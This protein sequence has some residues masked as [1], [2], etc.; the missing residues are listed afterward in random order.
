MTTIYLPIAEVAVSLPLLL[1]I[2]GGVGLLSGL[3]GVGGGFLLTP[4]LI[5]VG[6]PPAVAVG[7]EANQLVAASLSG[8]VAH[9]R[10]GRIDLRMG[11]MLLAG[12]IAGSTVG[13]SLFA[14]LRASGQIDLVIKLM[15][16]TSPVKIRWLSPGRRN[17]PSRDQSGRHPPTSGFCAWRV[18][19]AG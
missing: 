16:V 18:I 9:W 11:W 8:I 3:F 2:G 4:L 12:G 19:Q 5:F 6:I 7:S 14:W 17:G 1:A 15:Y 13:V 10:G